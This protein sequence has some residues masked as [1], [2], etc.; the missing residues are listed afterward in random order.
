MLQATASGFLDRDSFID[1]TLL[2]RRARAAR[3]ETLPTHGAGAAGPDEEGGGL[4][5]LMSATTGV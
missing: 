4:Q 5:N 1:Q 2:R 3:P